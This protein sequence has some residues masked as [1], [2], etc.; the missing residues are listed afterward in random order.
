MDKGFGDGSKL[1]QKRAKLALPLLVAY[2]KA[3]NTITYGQLAQE[4][5]M[6]NPRNLNYVLGAVGRELKAL[7]RN[8]NAKIPPII[9]L[10][11]NKHKKTPQRGIGFHMPTKKFES[12]PR[13]RQE[14]ILH[15]LDRD[16][17]DYSRWDDV[18]DHFRLEPVIPAKS[19]QLEAIATKAKYGKGGG[20]TDD[21]R[22]LKEYVR[23]RPQAIGLP[24]KLTGEKEYAFLSADK[25]DVLFKSSSSWIGIEVKGVRSDDADIMRGIFQCVKYKALIEAAQRYEQVNVDSRVILVLGGKLPHPLR[26]VVGLL[27]IEVKDEIPVPAASQVSAKPSV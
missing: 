16:I 8:W 17:W 15:G 18:L 4:M 19:A 13:S 2:A 27:K 3:R 11:I 10:V 26:H 7:S 22:E 20:E 23:E 12:L 5:E 9:C 6:P 21:H 25:I 24:E 1:Y 14:E